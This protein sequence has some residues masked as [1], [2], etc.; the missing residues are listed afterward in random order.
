M[1]S[2]NYC[3]KIHNFF[4]HTVHCCTSI[5]PLSGWSSFV[6]DALRPLSWIDQSD[7]RWLVSTGSRRPEQTLAEKQKASWL[8]PLQSGMII[9]R[10]KTGRLCSRTGADNHLASISETWGSQRISITASTPATA[11]TLR[12]QMLSSADTTDY[13][14]AGVCRLWDS[15]MHPL[16]S[17]IK[18][19][20]SLWLIDW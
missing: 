3:W 5:H 1:S 11:C 6:P 20:L 8:M 15:R 9:A 17:A 12:F 10:P 7:Q 19:S 4:S 16:P 13:E 2:G 14:A 18:N